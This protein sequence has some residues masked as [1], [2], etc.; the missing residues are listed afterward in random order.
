MYRSQHITRGIALLAS[1]FL[2]GVGSIRAADL[3]AESAQKEAEQ[4]AILTS[5]AP[6]AEKALACKRLAVYGSSKSVPELAKLLPDA[7]LNSWARI[8]LEVIPGPE[9][10]EVLR[11]AAESLQG[12]ILIGTINSI[13]V[14]RDA[15]A[16][17]SLTKLMQNEDAEVAAAAAVALG[18]VGN[19][20]AAKTLKNVLAS[21][22]L[23]VRSAVAEG[24]VLC[25]ERFRLE[26]RD[27]D[28]IALYDDVRAADVPKQRILEATR[29]AILARKDNGIPL[30]IEQFKSFDKGLFQIALSTAREFPG[31]AVDQAL[32]TEMA[33]T[34][35]DRAAPI[36]GAMADRPETVVLPAILK[37]ATG[38]A[39]EVRIAAL[40]ALGRVGN[41]SC[42]QTLLDSAIEPDAEISA[43][44]KKSLAEIPG[45]NV[46]KN[47]V[48]RLAKAEGKVYPVLLELVGQRRIEAL[49]Q[50]LKAID[51]ADAAV[52]TAA[53]TSLGTTVPPEKLSVL[54]K[55]AVSPK[56]AEDAAVAQQALKTASVRMPDREVCAKELS[57][58]LERAPVATQI[59]LLK[60]LG[61]VAGT[62]ALQTIADA[63]K[64]PDPQIQD[65]ASEL[66]GNWQTI[67]AAPVLLGLTKSAP[68]DK[69]R[70]RAM[71]GYIK[72]ARQFTMSDAERIEMCHK[73][74]E[75]CFRT[76]ERKLVIEVL[77]RYP[78][79]DT[80][81]LA[82][83][84][85]NDP[86]LKDDASAAVLVI[87]AKLTQSV[88]EVRALL[89]KV[90]INKASVEIVKGEY[91]A[92]AM[93]KDVTEVLL[94]HLG[95]TP[96]I[97]LPS[98]NYSEVFGGDPAPGTAKQL[99]IQYKLN[100][101]AGDVALGEN[102]LVILPVPKEKK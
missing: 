28:S 13:G 27:A 36:I 80:L 46:D 57:A 73:A 78:S 20:A 100:G 59:V 67:D 86:E 102:T 47:I 21:A 62:K 9:A 66:L 26:G 90:D 6:S 93:Q 61:E 82:I 79:L 3:A 31:T 7:Q 10:D 92:G 91:G 88:A 52:R 101:V 72:I 33:K 69:F 37:A 5:D 63:A 76:A 34:T 74:T 25:A 56:H 41:T 85:T 81:K 18:R 17:E 16:V 51:H 43:S 65:A 29:G 68:E 48:T 35:P 11:Q 1:T 50:L 89:S 19:D 23:G 45:E 22:R 97:V 94:K 14:R 30:L 49:Q 15:N 55:F 4:L 38:T 24:C 77:R 99:K 42:M 70:I 12:R 8:P 87:A 60:I 71:R 96:W 98:D 40:N 44:A 2:I 53:L 32:A 83:D 75:A 54:I 64:N 58:A 39:K 95:E 84:A